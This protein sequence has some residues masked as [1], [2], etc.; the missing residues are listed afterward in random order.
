MYGEFIK[1]KND[2]LKEKEILYKQMIDL[3]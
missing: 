1:E 2:R 3:K